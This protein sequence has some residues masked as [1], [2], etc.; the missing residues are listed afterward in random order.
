MT[1]AVLGVD[2]GTRKSGYA[3]LDPE[4]N[5]RAQGVVASA[6]L[7]ST[8]ASLVAG[9]PGAVIALGRGTHAEPVRQA[10][11]A[12][13]GLPIVLVDEHETTLRARALYFAEHPPRGWRRLIPLGLQVPPRPVD[14][15]AAILIGRRYLE[16][17]R[18]AF[19]GTS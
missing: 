7:P 4:G 9:H 14:D 12:V 5:A 8:L 2:P 19:P 11:V 10:L 15:Y 18:G 13:L 16:V 1:T 6:D 3:L 17:E